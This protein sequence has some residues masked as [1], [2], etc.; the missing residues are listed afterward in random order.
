LEGSFKYLNYHL[1]SF[2]LSTNHHNMY[3]S[4]EAIENATRINIDKVG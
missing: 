4:N 3:V 2:F 1:A